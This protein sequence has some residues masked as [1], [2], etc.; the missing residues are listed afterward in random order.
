M[1]R[2]IREFRGEFNQ[3]EKLV[4]KY[5]A[6]IPDCTLMEG[7]ISHNLDKNLKMSNSIIVWSENLNGDD[8]VLETL[9]NESEDIL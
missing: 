8:W 9:N 4:Y 2:I 6:E 1:P 3:F 7:Y 5:L